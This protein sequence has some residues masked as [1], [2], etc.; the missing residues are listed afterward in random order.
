MTTDDESPGEVAD[1]RLHGEDA[2]LPDTRCD[3][4]LGN[5]GDAAV[6]QDAVLAEPEAEV[7]PA[8]SPTE[9]AMKPS[10]ADPGCNIA[11]APCTSPTLAGE[12][13]N[14][15][16]ACQAEPPTDLSGA[17]TAGSLCSIDLRADNGLSASVET[18]PFAPRCLDVADEPRSKGAKAR[19][20]AA[21]SSLMPSL[22][23]REDSSGRLSDLPLAF[24]ANTSGMEGRPHM[25]HTGLSSDALAPRASKPS[26]RS[27]SVTPV[28]LQDHEEEAVDHRCDPLTP[29]R[30]WR[31][32]ASESVTATAA[33]ISEQALLLKAELAA[34]E[35]KPLQDMP[36]EAKDRAVRLAEQF[37]HSAAALGEAT[38][39]LAGH[40]GDR[41]ADLD[42]RY[43][44]R[45]QAAEMVSQGTEFVA[46]QV[47]SLS[48]DRA[49]RTTSRKED[50]AKAE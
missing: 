42:D 26:V 18:A 46:M 28:V 40:L 48:R 47:R 39:E 38:R 31:E 4:F 10:D 16:Q 5:R 22:V 1:D 20:S 8:A 36:E 24:A 33:A 49:P 41:V 6:A 3:D 2:I 35:G 32:V 27:P 34:F 45:Q 44:L 7:A 17:G 12:T 13:E 50:K 19:G 21:S 23:F 11:P 25:Q 15:L 29:L 9:W 30:D 14:S 43:H 37:K